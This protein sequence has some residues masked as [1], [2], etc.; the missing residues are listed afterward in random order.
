MEKWKHYYDHLIPYRINK[1]GALAEWIP[2]NYADNYSHRHNSHLYPVFPGTEFLQ[3]NSDTAL[4]NATRI[5]L[6]KRF[7][8]DTESAHGLIHVALMAARLHDK[9]KV[10]TNLD[11]FSRRNYVYSGL[12]TSHNPDHAIYNLDG[13]LSLQRLVSEML[14]F[15]Q[16]GRIELLPACPK[17]FPKENYPG[18]GYMVVISLILA[19]LKVGFSRQPIHAGRNDTCEFILGN[20]S[21]TIRLLAGKQYTFDRLLKLVKS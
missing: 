8:Y 20:K 18:F 7:K 21:T 10:L 3:P 17:D 12:V 14:V 19:G 5:A 16:P 2:E 1:D 4:L 11:R 15:S 9:E 6:T 13:V